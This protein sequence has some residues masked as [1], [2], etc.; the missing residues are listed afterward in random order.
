MKLNYF[1]RGISSSKVNFGLSVG[2]QIFSPNNTYLTELI[3]YDRP[4][5]GWL[6]TGFAVSLKQDDTAQFFE[7]DIGLIGPSALGK[8][9]QN[10][11]HDLIRTRRAEGWQHSLNDEPTLQLFY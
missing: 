3:P 2:H 9:V 4:Y 1:D 5:A 8:Q 11:F 10:N 6:Y 7:F